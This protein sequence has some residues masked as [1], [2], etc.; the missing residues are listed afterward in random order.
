MNATERAEYV[1]EADRFY[2]NPSTFMNQEMGQP[3][4]VRSSLG[5][6]LAPQGLGYGNGNKVGDDAN[7]RRGKK[8]WPEY[9]VFFQQAEEMLRTALKGS[10]Y[11][12]CW[13]RFNSHWHDDWRRSGDVIVWC[14]QKRS[15]S[16]I[17]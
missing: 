5:F 10:G 4:R 12:Q 2:A 14:L 6:K 11:R 1:D 15:W 17:V 16:R 7:G 9:L 3:P 8:E 13:R